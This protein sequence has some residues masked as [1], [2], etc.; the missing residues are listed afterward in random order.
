MAGYVPREW[1]GKR[2]MIRLV[3]KGILEGSLVDHKDGGVFFEVAAEEQSTRTLFIPWYSILY[4][5]LLEPADERPR[6]GPVKKP[7][8]A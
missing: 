7:P 3:T 8:G 6:L 4:V 5:E 2:V 1:H